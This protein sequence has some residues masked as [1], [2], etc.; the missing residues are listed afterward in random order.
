[1][2]NFLESDPRNF[3]GMWRNYLRIRVSIDLNRPLKNRMKIKKPGGEWLWIQFKY[4]RLPSFCFYCGRIGHTEKFCEEMF[5]NTQSSEGRRYDSSLRAPVR[6]QGLSK[7]N[8]WLRGANGAV[9]IPVKLDDKKEEDGGGMEAPP[10]EDS[11]I[12]AGGEHNPRKSGNY[13]IRSEIRGGDQAKVVTEI[14]PTDMIHSNERREINKTGKDTTGLLISDPKRRRIDGLEEN[15]PNIDNS[16]ED[17]AMKE[18]HTSESENQKNML[19]AGTA[20]QSRLGL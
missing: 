12:G 1:M 9:L 15:G 20:R 8:Q 13:E 11:E 7:E 16:V 10:V 4:E 2:G 6:G 18:A 14:E 17:I 5:D 19:E 3:Q